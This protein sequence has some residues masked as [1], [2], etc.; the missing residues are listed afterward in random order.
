MTIVLI[1]GTQN[2]HLSIASKLIDNFE[3][4]WIR[5]KRK[6]VPQVDQIQ[7]NFL[8]EHLEKLV[9]DETDELGIFNINEIL[10]SKNIIK[11]L[12]IDSLKNFNKLS[13]KFLESFEFN[14]DATVI[15]GSGIIG[16]DF[17]KVL[18]QPLINI[19]GGIS[20]Y[21]KGSSTL[22]YALALGQP[23]LLGMTI[24]EIDSGIDSG[25]IFCHLLPDLK[26]G[27]SPTK[28][29][30]SCQKKLYEEIENIINKIIEGS[31][32]S[33]PQSKF[34]RTFMER[35]Y[36]EAI[37]KSI[38]TMYEEGF[39]NLSISE[40]KKLRNKYKLREC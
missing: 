37:L 1:T 35:D 26:F 32:T 36:R 33:V 38:Y 7:S 19:H 5:Y 17:M 16:D 29:F 21:F 18:P 14:A 22:L 39:F 6:L 11:S 2:R 3:V 4:I 40:L 12:E 28:M 31:L 15:Y 23:E 13:P 9:K 8:K 25:D 10:K 30:A 24:H 34:G 20:P 27:M